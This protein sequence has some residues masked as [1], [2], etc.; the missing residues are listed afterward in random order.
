MA[1][2]LIYAPSGEIIQ[3]KRL[4]ITDPERRANMARSVTR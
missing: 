1:D 4:F 3:E 2:T